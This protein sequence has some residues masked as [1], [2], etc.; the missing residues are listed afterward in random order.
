MRHFNRDFDTLGGFSKRKIQVK[1]EVLAAALVL[2]FSAAAGVEY[3][4]ENIAEYV[5]YG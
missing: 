2:R 3:V 1:P 5:A 4:P